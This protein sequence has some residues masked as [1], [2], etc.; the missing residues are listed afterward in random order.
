MLLIVRYFLMCVL[1]VTVVINVSRILIVR[2][3]LRGIAD[4]AP[5]AAAD[6]DV[7][8]DVVVTA[9]V[10]V[11][12]T[13][14]CVVALPLVNMLA[15]GWSMSRSVRR[16]ARDRRSPGEVEPPGAPCS[17]GASHEAQDLP[18]GLDSHPPDAEVFR[19]AA[20]TRRPAPS[21]TTGLRGPPGRVP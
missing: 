9:D 20:V 11:T 2:G 18:R 15:D 7:T 21:P 6:A 10:V 13:A 1:L 3:A 19:R 17:A 4:G 5:I 12:G 8:T 16:R 14:W